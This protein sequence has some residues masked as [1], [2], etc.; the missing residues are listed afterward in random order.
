MLTVQLC[1]GARVKTNANNDVTNVVMIGV[2]LLSFVLLFRPASG[3]SKHKI[4]VNVNI[5]GQ[6]N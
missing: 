1:G 5:N 3:P 6:S 4:C 2:V